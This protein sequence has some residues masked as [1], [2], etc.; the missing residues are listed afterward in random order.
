MGHRTKSIFLELEHKTSYVKQYIYSITG[1]ISTCM[2]D[3]IKDFTLLTWCVL[4]ESYL[5]LF[6]REHENK[7]N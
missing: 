6:L 3:N 2:Q 7:E 1:I 5:L 4:Y